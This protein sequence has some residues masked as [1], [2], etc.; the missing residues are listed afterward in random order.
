[1]NKYNNYNNPYFINELFKNSIIKN[2]FWTEFSPAYSVNRSRFSNDSFLREKI[3]TF[4]KPNYILPPFKK[5]AHSH[6]NPFNLI[7]KYYD[8]NYIMEEELKKK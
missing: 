5:R 4:K 1:M 2:N 7:H 8:M 6:E 3:I